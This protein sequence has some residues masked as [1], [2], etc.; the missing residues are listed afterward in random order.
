M[1][2]HP[3]CSKKWLRDPEIVEG[4]FFHGLCF[5]ICI[6]GF[7]SNIFVIVVMRRPKLRDQ[8]VSFLL[9]SLAVFDTLKLITGIFMVAEN[10]L[11]PIFQKTNT[12]FTS[13]LSCA[14]F[15]FLQKFFTN[16][17]IWLVFGVIL[18]R[19]TWVY[20]RERQVI[21]RSRAKVVVAA[22]VFINFCANV[23]YIVTTKYNEKKK[24]CSSR[25][26]YEEYCYYRTEF[27]GI[28]ECV[29]KL[30]PLFLNVILTFLIILKIMYQWT[31]GDRR[32]SQQRL[33]ASENDTNAQLLRMT[34]T[35]C[36]VSTL[37]LV[38]PN[39]N[40][41]YGK[42]TERST[43]PKGRNGAITTPI[44]PLVDVNE[45]SFLSMNGVDFNADISKDM[46]N[47][48]PLKGVRERF[49]GGGGGGTNH[50]KKTKEEN[51]MS[52]E[53]CVVSVI[54]TYIAGRPF[55]LLNHAINCFLLIVSA[56]TFRQ[57]FV[58]MMRD[59]CKCCSSGKNAPVE[60]SPASESM[61]AAEDE[62]ENENESENENEN[63][64]ENENENENEI[65][66][67]DSA[68]D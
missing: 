40:S 46:D 37:I 41:A 44:S 65:G 13:N 63:E 66:R 64:S 1:S 11:L 60:D 20:Y 42:F 26:Y 14:T 3:W 52:T 43:C 48:D 18:E 27:K 38:P 29:W 22:I 35:V 53:E 32:K 25:D 55:F 68:Q 30:F 16:T 58:G 59:C 2:S 21:N 39:V 7:I 10:S 28:A 36:L 50:S 34:V 12:F 5:S 45:T 57:E 56:A 19:F 6:I 49:A 17:A 15:M 47:E 67:T 61:M 23:D 8:P 54:R 4:Q 33:N 51:A 9:I 24:K 62:N 31:N